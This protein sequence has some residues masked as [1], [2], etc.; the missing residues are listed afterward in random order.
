MAKRTTQKSRN[1]AD[2]TE[3]ELETVREMRRRVFSLLR[4]VCDHEDALEKRLGELQQGQVDEQVAALTAETIF[5]EFEKITDQ[6]HEMGEWFDAQD[7][8]FDAWAESL[9]TD[10]VLA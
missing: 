10:E 4:N 3:G 6:A 7:V 8:E 1:L 5:A 2:I 9:A